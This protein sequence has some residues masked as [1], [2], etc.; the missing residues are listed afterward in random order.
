MI[1]ETVSMLSERSSSTAYELSGHDLIAALRERHG[2]A[3][4]DH[5]VTLV[6]DGGFA[7]SLDSN[8]GNLLSLIGGNLIENALHAA[9]ADSVVRVTL[10]LIDHR[11]AL[12]VAD[13]GRGIPDELLHRLFQPGRSSK[14]GG[15]GLGL[16]ISHLL[17]L[18]I[19]AELALVRTGP[20]GT[21][22]SVSL[23]LRPEQ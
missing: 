23:P 1:Q 19:G 11:I 12:S 21:L 6:V 14:P 13:E 2:P 7:A 15:T 16:A 5:G 8:R 9:P 17:A 3:A 20:T 22:F 4:R 10:D 18:E